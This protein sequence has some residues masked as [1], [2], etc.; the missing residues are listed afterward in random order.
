[1]SYSSR[2]A[3]YYAPEI[4]SELADF[5]ANWLGWDAQTSQSV[6]HL[7]YDDLPV[8]DITAT[9][10]KYGF[11]GTL[12]PPFRLAYGKTVADLNEA[13][14]ELAAHQSAFEIESIALRMLDGFLAIMPTKNNAE[15]SALADTCVRDLDWL[16]A[17]LGAEDLLR[18]RAANLTPRQ[19]KHLTEWGY[20]YV[21]EDFRF[22]LTLTGKLSTDL[23]SA[24]QDLLLHRLAR[25]LS[26]SLAIRE[27]CL[28]R[29][30]SDG[31]FY[32]FKRYPLASFP[33]MRPEKLNT[34][35][36]ADHRSG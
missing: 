31:R 16:R 13:M 33:A 14:A 17:P 22:H 36:P 2:Y 30:N 18:R 4:N 28:F 21:F 19:E 7:I 32:V 27:I 6:P 9:P 3:V 10:R 34:R 11:H 1:M 20:P 5:G 26:R 29:E 24:V 8:S 23:A 15:I 25:P 35:L 12:K